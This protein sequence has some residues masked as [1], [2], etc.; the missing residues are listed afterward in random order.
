MSQLPIQDGEYRTQ[1]RRVSF[2]S[3]WFPSTVFFLKLAWIIWKAGRKA[4]AGKYDGGEWAKSSLAVMRALESVGVKFEITGFEHFDSI[5]GP[6]LVVGNHMSTL[7]TTVLPGLIQPIKESTFVIKQSLLEYPVFKHVMR[8][9]DPIAVSQSD[10]RAD[11]KTMLT[12][13]AERLARGVS[14]IVFPEGERAAE[15]VPAKF[16]T[17]GVKIAQRNEVPIVPLALDSWAWPLGAVV[18]D[19]ARLDTDRKVRFAFGP[20]LEVSGRG[21]EE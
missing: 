19:V 9:R 16:N 14:V 2:L 5:E 10:V 18:S 17:I 1:P 12:G 6:C 13:A 7:E 3:R 11:F 8:S 4:K 15:F 20:P 21:A